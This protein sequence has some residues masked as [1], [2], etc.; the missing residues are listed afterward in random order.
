MALFERG[1]TPW[2]RGLTKENDTRVALYGKKGGETKKG[3]PL[4]H[5]GQFK[6]G[7]VPWNAGKHI[8][9]G[10]HNGLVG[11]KNPNWKGGPK[12]IQ[13]FRR[14][15][16][17]RLWR[18]AIFEKDD[19]TCQKCGVRGGKLIADHHPFPFHAF[20]DKMYDIGNGRT[21]CSKCNYVV[22]YIEQNWRVAP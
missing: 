18:K 7:F 20:P 22:T 12:K 19:F 1:H 17:Y 11:E 2:N 21:L 5:R 14:T 9:F 3:K 16:E 13:E 8:R 6:K 4:K 10:G 15:I